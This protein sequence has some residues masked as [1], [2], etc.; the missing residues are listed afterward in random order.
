[1]SDIK[2]KRKKPTKKRGNNGR[3]IK[4]KSVSGVRTLYPREQADS[5]EVAEL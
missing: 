1:M 2:R 4:G 5:N 3:R